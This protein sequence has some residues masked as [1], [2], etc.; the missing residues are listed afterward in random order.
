MSA[1]GYTTDRV[2]IV[3]SLFCDHL[4]LLGDARCG[5]CDGFGIRT[6]QEAV[7]GTTIVRGARADNHTPIRGAV[8][9][10]RRGLPLVWDGQEFHLLSS[11]ERVSEAEARSA[12]QDPRR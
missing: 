12:L 4:V 2:M 11:W 10:A 1:I 8:V 6:M 7:E 5:Q 3:P 9:A